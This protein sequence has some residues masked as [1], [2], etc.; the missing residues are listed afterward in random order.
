MRGYFIV[1][2]GIDGCGKTTQLEMASRYIKEK[3]PNR[4][5]V[6]TKEPTTNEIGTFIRKIISSK[7]N[8]DPIAMQLLFSADRALHVSE[9]MSIINK[10]GIVL[11]D[12]YMFSTFAYGASNGLDMD[13]L[14]YINKKFLVPDLTFIIDTPAEI[15]IER[16][17]KRE[18]EKKLKMYEK[19]NILNSARSEYLK[20][21]EYFKNYFIIDGNRNIEEINK[22]IINILELNLI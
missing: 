16:I 19:I 10:G 8:F 21:K 18:K 14:R 1:F 6:I 3:Y 2:E 4:E 12:R 7:E 5:L 11:C 22:E 20:M 9:I 15:S 13:F 17:L